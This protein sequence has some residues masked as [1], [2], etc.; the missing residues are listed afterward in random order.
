MKQQRLSTVRRIR[1]EPLGDPQ[2]ASE[3]VEFTFDHERTWSD[4]IQFGVLRGN[5]LLLC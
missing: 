4:G 3:L 5:R 1:I 2:V